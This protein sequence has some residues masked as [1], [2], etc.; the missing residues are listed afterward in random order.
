MWSNPFRRRSRLRRANTPRQPELSDDE[1]D[2]EANALTGIG[3]PLS[4]RG[5]N[6]TPS[7]ALVNRTHVESPYTG[8]S[9]GRNRSAASE[10]SLEATA[11]GMLGIAMQQAAGDTRFQKDLNAAIEV[12]TI[13]AVQGLPEGRWEGCAFECALCL[14]TV[15]TGCRVRRLGCLHRY[16]TDCIDRWLCTAQSGQRRRCPLCN[17]D[18]LTGDGADTY[19]AI[20]P[21]PEAPSASRVEPPASSSATQSSGILFG[22]VPVENLIP[23]WAM[24]S[25]EQ[26]DPQQALYSA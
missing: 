26:Q 20:E 7:R 5:T 3:Q 21:V 19:S 2:I 6:G 1:S 16:H 10:G 23:Q 22:G 9:R 12:S 13:A 15:S 11:Y 14:E 18:P 4:Q 25:I 8:P 24:P 17:A